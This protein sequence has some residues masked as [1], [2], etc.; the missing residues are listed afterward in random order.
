MDNWDTSPAATYAE[1]AI[2]FRRALGATSH[3]IIS[4]QNH[5]QQWRDW[6]A[7]YGFRKLLGSQDIMR[8]KA[9]KTVP[10]LSPF[11]FDSEFNPSR[12]SPM[13][14]WDGHEIPIHQ[15]DEQRRRVVELMARFAGRSVESLAPNRY[16]KP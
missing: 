1:K 14:P 10:T 15:T 12:P 3:P 9:E 11:D 13:V 4:R 2:D 6:Y 8:S 7:Y 16:K 5:P